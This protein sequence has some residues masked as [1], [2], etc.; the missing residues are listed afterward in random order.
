MSVTFLFR[1]LHAFAVHV[2]MS[3]ILNVDRHRV[4]ALA[5]KQAVSMFESGITL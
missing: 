5:S 3:N 2:T 4:L 1:A